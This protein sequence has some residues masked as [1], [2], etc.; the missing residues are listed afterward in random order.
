M[1]CKAGLFVVLNDVN[2]FIESR[3]VQNGQLFCKDEVKITFFPTLPST[4][5][6]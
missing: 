3:F 5:P 6:R 2:F 1:V 4:S